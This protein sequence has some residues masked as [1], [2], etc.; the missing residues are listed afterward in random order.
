MPGRMPEV[1]TVMRDSGMPMPST[2]RRT[3]CHEGVV[4]QEGLAHAH[5]DEVDAVWLPMLRL[6]VAVEDGGDLAGDLARGE[7]AADAE[8]RGEAELAVDGAADLAGDAD[9]R[10][11][12]PASA[13]A[14]KLLAD[15][16][17]LAAPS[18]RVLRGSSS[19]PGAS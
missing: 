7:V 11:A 14:P 13:S 9:G 4:V 12:I 5:E 16:H 2:S 18:S 19:S 6:R 10:P 15:G 1:E 3:R 17:C 8:L